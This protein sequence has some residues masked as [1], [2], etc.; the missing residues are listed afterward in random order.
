MTAG[1]LGV[2]GGTQA[3]EETQTRQQLIAAAAFHFFAHSITCRDSLLG[4]GLVLPLHSLVGGGIPV[5]MASPDHAHKLQ[6]K[7]E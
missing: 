7:T 6:E 5:G 1:R 3:L 4:S 2:E